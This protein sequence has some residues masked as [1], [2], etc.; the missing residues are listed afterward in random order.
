MASSDEIER[1]KARDRGFLSSADRKWLL[2]PREEYIEEHSRQYW[3]QRRDEVRKRVGNALLDFSLL[4][5]HWDESEHDYIFGDA[6]NPPQPIADPGVRE[7]TVDTLALILR[8]TGVMNLVGPNRYN[9]KAVEASNLL[10]QAIYNVGL[11]QNYLV[12]DVQLK[13]EAEMFPEPNMIRALE[14]GRNLSGRAL[15]YFMAREDVDTTEIQE[16]IREQI[17]GDAE[18]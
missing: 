9:P 11:R 15:L 5:E 6:D 3:G 8:A 13:I 1:E 14:E 16:Q 12:D 7:G 18:D 10:E 17:L 2:T 4:W